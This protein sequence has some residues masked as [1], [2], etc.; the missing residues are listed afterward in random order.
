MKLSF[1]HKAE[2]N[3][4]NGRL[5]L[6][7][8]GWSTSPDF[9]SDC[10]RDGWDTAVV[11]D[12][13][14]MSLEIDDVLNGYNTVFLIAWSMGVAAAEIW[15]SEHPGAASAITAA[16]AVNGTLR[17]RSDKFGIPKL[18]YDATRKNLSPLALQKFRRRMDSSRTVFHPVPEMPE[19]DKD[20]IER[21]RHQLDIFADVRIYD[22]RLPW[23]R[24]FVGVNDRIYPAENQLQCW[25]ELAP[26]AC[27][28]ELMAEHYIPLSYVA[29]RVTPDCRVIGEH[30]RRS[31]GSYPEHAVAQHRIAAH[32]LS[33]VPENMRSAKNMRMVEIGPGS[34]TLTGMLPRCLDV[35]EAVFVDLFS[36]EKPFGIAPHEEYVTGDAEEWM[37]SAP[38]ESF[39]VVVSA[40]VIQW[41]ANPGRFLSNARRILRSG[42]LLLC[43]TFVQGNLEELDSFRPAPLLY[44]TAGELEEMV[45][46]CFDSF[47]VEEDCIRLDFPTT[48]YLLLHLKHTGVAGSSHAAKPVSRLTATTL[49]YRPLYIIAE[50]QPGEQPTNAPFPG[51]F[52]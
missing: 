6:L 41:F 37:E 2:G 32:L 25:K 45:A 49:T 19:V 16:I 11:W 10:R 18:V 35:K 14:D 5:L 20:G 4:R 15:A 3:Q 1:L 29:G 44:H 31:A 40:S 24:V 51:N 43:S 47:S 13:D 46:D 42:G 38:S 8:A 17:P 30:F 34:G 52:S 48:R 50:K 23:R 7:F 36:N 21:L 39:D 26:S 28:E 27:V 22:P 9:Y 33:L 12:Y